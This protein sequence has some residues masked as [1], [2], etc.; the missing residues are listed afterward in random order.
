MISFTPNPIAVRLG[1]IPVYWYGIAYAVGL[2]VSYLVLVRQARTFRQD[3]E[4]IGN[5]LIVIAIA[6]LV[7]GRLY[8]VI[9][10]WNLYRDN[11]LKI[12]LPP[13][14]GLGV[15]GGLITGVLAFLVLVR[16]HRVNGW[17]WADIVAPA[18]FTMQAIGRWG[19]FFNQELFG[20]PTNLPW[21][22]AIDCA[23]RFSDHGAAIFPCGQ[24]P[25]ATTFFTPLFLYESISGVLGAL[26]LIWLS[27]RRPYPLRPGD[28]ILIFFIWYAVVRFLLENLRTGNWFVGGI[29]T[30]QLMSIAFGLGAFLMLL[31]RHRRPVVHAASAGDLAGIDDTGGPEVDRED[32]DE[33]WKDGDLGAAPTAGAASGEAGTPLPETPPPETPPPGEPAPDVTPP[34]IG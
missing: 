31:Y 19:N 4:L 18:L 27:R 17:I 5:G 9:D 34:P 2:L 21:G 24:Y 25:E 10:Q 3:V 29:P 32:D 7:G 13:Y 22:I 14:S 12:V 8:H 28:Q 30:V 1:P 11:L 26:F 20:P 16:Y 23:H 33:E 15:Y 6:A